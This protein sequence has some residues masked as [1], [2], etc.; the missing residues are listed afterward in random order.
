MGIDFDLLNRSAD[1]TRLAGVPA[2]NDK[3]MTRSK[4]GREQH[5]ACPFCGTG[6]DRFWINIDEQPQTW[7]CR[8]CKK[9]GDA[10]QFIA[11]REHLDRHN[12][13]IQIADILARE[14]NIT[15]C[16]HAAAVPVIKPEPTKTITDNNPPS[17]EWQAAAR[18]F[19]GR[20]QQLLPGSP[21]YE[22]MRSRGFDLATLERFNIGYNPSWYK[23]R[24]GSENLNIAPGITIPTFTNN[25]L[26]RVKIRIYEL[27][28]KGPKYMSIKGSINHTLYNEIDAR[29]KELLI[30]CEGEFDLMSIKQA[31]S[32]DVGVV[33]FGSAGMTP[34]VTTPDMFKYF[35]L[36]DKIII[37]F[38]NDE[39]GEAGALKLLE[40]IQS[41]IN[42]PAEIKRLPAQYHDWNDA[43]KKHADIRRLLFDMFGTK[44]TAVHQHGG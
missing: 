26:V 6:T 20:C 14:L 13:A 10:M 24:I 23:L 28:N 37:S 43:L 1:I 9:G 35:Y 33:T 22:Y 16:E 17:I 25:N 36:P 31:A 41:K 7:Y 11:E 8:Q 38:D 2:A 34:D 40:E 42:T 3:L 4:N 21:G 44:E 18:K 32:E 19:I 27:D 15:S 39:A 30:I 29:E 12:D 5:S